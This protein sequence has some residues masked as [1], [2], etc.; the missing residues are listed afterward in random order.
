[1][2]DSDALLARREELNVNSFVP[3]ELAGFERANHPSSLM[4]AAVDATRDT[5]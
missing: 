1:M 3:H 2:A 4:I 5:R